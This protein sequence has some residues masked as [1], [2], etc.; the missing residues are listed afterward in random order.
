MV[1]EFPDIIPN[2]AIK[3]LRDS[4]THDNGEKYKTS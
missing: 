4:K 1:H 2:W 3:L